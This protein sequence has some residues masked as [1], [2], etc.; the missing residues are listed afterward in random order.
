MSDKTHTYTNGE[1]TIVWKPSLCTHSKR[2]WMGLPTVF[3]PGQRPWILPEGA[4]TDAIVAQ[5]GKC[6]SGA[7]SIRMNAEGAGSAADGS[8]QDPA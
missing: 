7:L 4:N 8:I 1:V 2:C 3:K 5:V 6:P